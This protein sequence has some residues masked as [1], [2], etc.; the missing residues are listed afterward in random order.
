M[1]GAPLGGG[2]EEKKATKWKAKK[3]GGEEESATNCTHDRSPIPGLVVNAFLKVSHKTRRFLRDGF[4]PAMHP[5]RVPIL[6]LQ[7]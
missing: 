6:H 7:D 4:V 1:K 3:K 2:E 5:P